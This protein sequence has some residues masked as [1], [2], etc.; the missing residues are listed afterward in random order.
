M[1]FLPG[2][3]WLLLSKIA[4]RLIYSLYR[5]RASAFLAG[6]SL[7]KNSWPMTWSFST[8]RTK[9]GE[10]WTRCEMRVI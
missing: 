6:E 9:R 7:P 3:A 5:N 1:L 4:G 2:S 8:S 10:K